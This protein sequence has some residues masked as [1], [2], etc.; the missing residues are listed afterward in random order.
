MHIKHVIVQTPS[1]LRGISCNQCLLTQI[2]GT[3]HW[4]ALQEHCTLLKQV[5]GSWHLP[6]PKQL[7]NIL[8]RGSPLPE[9]LWGGSF[10]F[11]FFNLVT[12]LIEV[13]L[14]YNILVFEV[15][16]R[17]IWYFTHYEMI[18]RVSLVTICHHTKWPQLYWLY[19]LCVYYIPMA[20]LLY[21][22]KFVLRNPL[23]LYH[24]PLPLLPPLVTISLLPSSLCLFLF[25]S[26]C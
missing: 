9:C 16:I 10:I 13:S 4:G 17:V 19:S 18:F 12:F 11:Y 15:Y 7:H 21:T 22:W 20:Y 1:T 14:I 5:L 26:V 6:G 25:C 8:G 3:L 24:L 23:H 2:L